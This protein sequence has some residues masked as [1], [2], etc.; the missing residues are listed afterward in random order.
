MIRVVDNAKSGPHSLD[1]METD[2]EE[3]L[4]L[5]AKQGSHAAFS[6]LIRLHHG[7][8]RAT[9]GRCLRDDDEVDEL[10]QRV[11]VSAYHSLSQFRQEASF[12][13]WLIA[14]AR[15]QVAMYIR[16]ESRRRRHETSA[17]EAALLTWTEQAGEQEDDTAA[18]L[19]A[20]AEC[21]K[22][23]PA[24][25]HEVV[26]RFYFG[27]QKIEV[28]AK[29]QSRSCGAVRMLLM[30]IRKRLAKCISRRLAE[31]EEER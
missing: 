15:R 3:T 27:R 18:R 10:A 7:V 12:R 24:G 1:A 4:I 28:I 20:L 22:Q 5:Q 6:E 11:F 13:G 23:L 2:S 31:S 14:I 21:L 25:S 8:V 30:R 9:L 29:G 16:S 17:A 19:S 26:N